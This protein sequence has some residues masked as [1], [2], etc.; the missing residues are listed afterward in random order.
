MIFFLFKL[1]IFETIEKKIIINYKNLIL[2]LTFFFRKKIYFKKQNENDFKLCMLKYYR[3]KYTLYTQIYTYKKRNS[4][5][6]NKF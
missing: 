5:R 3:Y 2:Y 1:N 6:Y 4:D